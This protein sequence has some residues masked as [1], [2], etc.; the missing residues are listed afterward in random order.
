M[1]ATADAADGDCMFTLTG[2]ASLNPDYL[3]VAVF[4][5][6]LSIL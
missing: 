6:F 5:L 4:H 1:V 3:Y 2:K